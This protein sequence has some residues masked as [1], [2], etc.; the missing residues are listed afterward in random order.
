MYAANVYTHTQII[1][2][3]QPYTCTHIWGQKV[4]R[5]K[6]GVIWKDIGQNA[7]SV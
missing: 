5:K 6:V 1:Y 3:Q 2:I 4:E 7:D